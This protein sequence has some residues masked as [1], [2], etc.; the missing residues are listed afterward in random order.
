MDRVSGL[1]KVRVFGLLGLIGYRF[2][3]LGLGCIG[4]K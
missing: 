3:V 2:R 4:F 1:D